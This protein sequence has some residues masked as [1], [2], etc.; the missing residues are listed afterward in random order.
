M[1]MTTKKKDIREVVERHLEAAYTEIQEDRGL[2]GDI[3]NMQAIELDNK[4]D[5]L[6]LCVI[7]WLDPFKG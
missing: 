4:T 2:S 7:R 6:V 1:A 3:E 5:D